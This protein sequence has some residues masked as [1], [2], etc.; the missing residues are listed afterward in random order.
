[1]AV[2]KYDDL[3]NP[4]LKALH[5]LG[6]SSSVVEME[7][8]VADI[9]KL[10]EKD[11][12][13]IHVGTRTKLSYRLAWARNYLKRYGLLVNSAKGVWALTPQGQKTTSVNKQEVNKIVKSQDRS[14]KKTEYHEEAE[15]DIEKWKDDLLEVIKKIPPADFERLCQRILREAG[16]IKVE[17]KGKSGDGGIDGIGMFKIAGFLTFRVIFQCKIYQGNVSSQQIREFKGTMV[18]RADKGLFITTGRFTRDAI[19]EANRDGSTPVDLVDGR[20]LVEKMK[21]LGLGV[22]VKQEETIDID[23]DWFKNF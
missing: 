20:E 14:D 7:E 1:M 17:V 18:G 8:K 4:L 10:S 21:E 22:N 16:F 3:F 19:E 5:E 11:I 9:L 12:N 13:E 15:Q 23:Q 6:G 2:P